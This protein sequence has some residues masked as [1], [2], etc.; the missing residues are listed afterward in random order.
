[1]L[2]V[3]VCLVPSPKSTTQSSTGVIFI[4]VKELPWIL[5]EEILFDLL[6]ETPNELNLYGIIIKL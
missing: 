5:N 4:E 3:Y 1:M 2:P 6:F